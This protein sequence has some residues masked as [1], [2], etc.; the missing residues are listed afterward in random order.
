MTD[1][2]D[3]LPIVDRVDGVYANVGH[4]WGIASGPIC[5]QTLAEIIAGEPSKFAEALRADR[6]GLEGRPT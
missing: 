6:V 5:G 4:A 2:P 1:T 3:H